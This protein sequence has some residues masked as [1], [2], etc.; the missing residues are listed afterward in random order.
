MKTLK[1]ETVYLMTYETFDDVAT[2]VPRFIEEAYN[3]RRLHSALG[4]VSPDRFED[5]HAQNCRLILSGHRGA[6]HETGDRRPKLTP[7]SCRRRRLSALRSGDVGCGDDCAHPARALDQG[8][9]DQGDRPGSEGVTEHGP[10][11]AAVR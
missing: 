4:Y 6:L 10:Q 9:D 7:L 3:A 11:G 2:D 1:V 5:Q 8:Q